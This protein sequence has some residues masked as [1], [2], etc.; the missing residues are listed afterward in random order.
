M[1]DAVVRWTK[2]L[3]PMRLLPVV[4]GALLWMLSPSAAAG[5]ATYVPVPGSPDVVLNPAHV[6]AVGSEFTQQC[7]GLPRPIQP[8][9]V[10]WHFVLPQS[11]LEL[12]PLGAPS[13]GN[14]FESL[15]V[16]FATA[17]V[18]LTTF[19]PPSSAHAYVFT[20]T[21]DTL[22]GGVADVLRRVDLLRA[23]EPL[24]NLS[25][26]V[27]RAIRDDDHGSDDDHGDGRLHGGAHLGR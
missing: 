1:L 6:G 3:V 8:G 17:G 18:T 20:P 12:D 10:A 27:R 15:T 22:E 21:D 16:E 4:A 13:P 9:E 23:N 19:G 14:I 5:Q 7:T 26:H 11:V 24:F 2:A 25:H